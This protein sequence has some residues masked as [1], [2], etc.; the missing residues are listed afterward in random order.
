[1]DSHPFARKEAKGWDTQLI[2]LIPS[3]YCVFQKMPWQL[4]IS[5][6]LKPFVFPVRFGMTE[7]VP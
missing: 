3:S 6:G 5:Q 7:V 4:V 2:F 1:V